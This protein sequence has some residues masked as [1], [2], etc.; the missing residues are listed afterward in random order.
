MF[1][2]IHEVSSAT[3]W[4]VTNYTQSKRKRRWESTNQKKHSHNDLFEC[5]LCYLHFAS[6]PCKTW[7]SLWDFMKVHRCNGNKSSEIFFQV[8]KQLLKVWEKVHRLWRPHNLDQL[9]WWIVWRRK[10]DKKKQK[11]TK[12]LTPLRHITWGRKRKKTLW[13]RPS[14]LLQQRQNEKNEV[15]CI[16]SKRRRKWVSSRTLGQEAARWCSSTRAAQLWEDGK[17]QI[18]FNDLFSYF[19]AEYCIV[20][21]WC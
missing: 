10:R 3:M 15:C 2:G 6:H 4:K 21:L 11:T 1:C 14:W 20:R 17:P 12:K 8:R 16:Y 9:E 13:P 18:C 5:Q 19:R 7:R